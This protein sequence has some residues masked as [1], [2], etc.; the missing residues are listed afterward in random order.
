[1]TLKKKKRK[2]AAAVISFQWIGYKSNTILAFKIRLL[3]NVSL[4]I[5][6][7]FSMLNCFLTELFQKLVQYKRITPQKTSL[8]L[9]AVTSFI[10]S[11]A[12]NAVT[13]VELQ[14][15]MSVAWVSSPENRELSF[16]VVQFFAHD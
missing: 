10:D 1:M 11:I 4:F 14:R 6:L 15:T 3:H 5:F 12:L 8:D 2:K 9:F 16:E 13:F 7:V